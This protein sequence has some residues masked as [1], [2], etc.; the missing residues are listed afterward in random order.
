MNKIEQKF[1]HIP[2]LLTEVLG[3]I[4]PK[5]GENFIDATLGGGGYSRSILEQIGSTGKVLAIDMDQDAIDNAKTQNPNTK[6]LILHHG[7]FKD[8]DKIVDHHKF[9][10]ISGI[11]ADLGLSSYELD[12]AGRGISFQ[13]KEPLDMRF[14]QSQKETAAF[15]LNN[16]DEKRLLNIFREFGEEK[17]SKQI[18]RKIQET[19]D[20]RQEIRYTTDLYQIIVDALPKPVKHKADDS[21]RRIFQALRIAV[22][23][24]LDNLS[25]FLPKA[26]NLLN[27]G[28][29]LAIVSFHSLEDRI[30]KQFFAS[31]AK[32]CV[33]PIDFPKCLCGKTPKGKY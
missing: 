23:H 31:L 29:R 20:K 15:I 8:I 13:K 19:R 2:V 18:A 24:E 14:D 25:E 17:F 6:N 7:N 12:Q 28:G 1:H 33:C 26:F 22:N 10:N 5:P 11:V 16:Y 9:E 27:S 3:L 32:G 4:N 30:V 21:A